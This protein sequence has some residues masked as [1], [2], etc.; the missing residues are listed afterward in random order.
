MLSRL[1]PLG[2]DERQQVCLPTLFQ[3]S[4]M[5]RAF[6]AISLQAALATAILTV[7]P[8]AGAATVGS[9]NDEAHAPQ[10]AAFVS[11]VSREQ[12][13]ADAVVA[14][15]QVYSHTDQQHEPQVA[16]ADST[17]TRAQVRAE[18]VAANRSGLNF[19][20]EYQ[21]AA[22][23]APQGLRVASATLAAAR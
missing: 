21:I 6:T 19:S 2:A 8:L 11:Q 5:N 15:R 1:S 17:L 7:A 12:V 20:S 9:F 16:T 4:L 22:G 14:A 10:L 23:A 13:R 3:E 18:A